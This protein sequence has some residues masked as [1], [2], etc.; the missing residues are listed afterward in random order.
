M[1]LS[2]GV[3]AAWAGEAGR[4]FAVVAQEVRALAQ[5]SAEAAKQIKTLISASS[6]QVGAGVGLVGQTG[7]ALSS[8]V[9]RVA[10]IDDLMRGI[11]ASS[12]E[13][14]SGLNEVNLAVNHMDQVVQQNAAMV[15]QATAATHSLK[16]ETAQ[17]VSLVSQFRVGGQRENLRMAG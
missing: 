5:R 14:A 3:E 7:E 8:I 12:H 13:Q 9:D 15:E 10:T 11:L 16:T 2:A 17:L 6:Q 4:G 1:A